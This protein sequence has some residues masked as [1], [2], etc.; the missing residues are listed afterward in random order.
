MAGDLPGKVVVLTGGASGIGRECALA[1]SRE[2]ATVAILDRDFETA[3]RTAAELGGQSMALHADVADGEA[4]RVAISAVMGRFGRIDAIHNNAGIASPSKPLHE[5]AEQEWDEIQRI[6]V[7]SVYWTT[8]FAFEAL[9]ASEGTILN[10][11][12]MVGL[13][14]QQDHAAYV[15]SKGAMISLTK[16]MAADYARYSIRVN[17]ICPAGVWTPML[18]QWCS[19]QQNP[20]SI[21]QYLNDIHLLGYCPRGDVIADAA[22]FL[23]SSQARFLTGCILPVTGGAELGYRR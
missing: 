6:N 14:G 12:S 17:A 4:I 22:V 19:E 5:T 11:A 10:T 3:K 2:A 9:V 18:E 1:Y 16:A 21:R 15:A 23:L 8:K 20:A 13:I 7:K